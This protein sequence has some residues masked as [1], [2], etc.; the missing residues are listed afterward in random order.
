ML[1]DGNN[2]IA[3]HLKNNKLFTAGKI[4]LTE[5]KLLYCYYTNNKTPDPDSFQEGL[6]NSGIFPLTQETYLYF[7]KTYIESI[8]CLDLAPQWCG[9]LR[10]FQKHLYDN[11]NSK[12]YNTRLGDLEPYYFD[13]P[14]SHH[15]TDKKVLVVSPFSR[16]IDSQF[17]NFDKIW[18]GKLKK[19]FYLE[20]LNFPLSK[21]LTDR[22]EYASYK[23][24]LDK[25]KEKIY[26][27]DFD[28]CI[29]GVGAYSLPLCS[30]VREMGKSSLHLG[31]AT[32]VMFGVKGDRWESIDR[33][34]AFFNEYWVNPTGDEVPEKYK[35]MENGCYW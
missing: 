34:K 25:T 33:V 26:K 19:N 4:G 28:F 2:F 17:N 20:T 14:W 27:K 32:Q 10:E 31:G 23:E 15:L 6:I 1:V 9:I 3:H 13:K 21:G 11:L 24:C 8:K 29:L 7:C 18:N 22:N 16:S 12:C 30:F 5:L 35:L